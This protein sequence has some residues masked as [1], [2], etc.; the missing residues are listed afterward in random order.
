MNSCDG[1]SACCKIMKVAELAKQ[2]NTWCQHCQIGVGC[3]IYETRPESCRVY[4]CL[5][6]RTQSLEKP[7]APELRPDKSR[8]VMGTTNHGEDVVLYVSADRPDA[9]KNSRISNVV[10]E[11][12]ARRINVFLS[13]GEKLERL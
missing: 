3:S 13:R 10:G 12:K 5:W 1:C 8:V 4:E 7:M 9:W 11:F 6:L 2:A